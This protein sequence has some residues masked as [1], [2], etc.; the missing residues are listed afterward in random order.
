MNVEKEKTKG[1]NIIQ[2]VDLN[3]TSKDFVNWFYTTLNSNIDNLFNNLWRDFTVVDINSE[4]T[5][6]KV[7]IHSKFN[8]CFY[9]IKI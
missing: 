7:N 6:G 2:K 8:K 3:I 9:R 4:K 5:K 1:D